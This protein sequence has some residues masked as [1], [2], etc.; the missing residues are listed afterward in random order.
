MR[1]HNKKYTSQYKLD[2]AGDIVAY[3]NRGGPKAASKSI[4]NRAVEMPSS[5]MAT[6]IAA[7]GLADRDPVTARP[8]LIGNK[9]YVDIPDIN[10][11]I[12]QALINKCYNPVGFELFQTIR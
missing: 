10:Q 4:R 11:I 2:W 5:A 7:L 1:R 8:Q 3:Q 12:I 6:A 9:I